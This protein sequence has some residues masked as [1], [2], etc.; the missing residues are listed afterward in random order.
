MDQP[1]IAVIIPCYNVENTINRV[2]NK[3]PEFVSSIIVVDDCSTD[4]TVKHVLSNPDPRLSLIGHKV[5]RGVGGAMLTGFS[6]GLKIGAHILVKLDGDDQMDSNY[7]TYLVEPLINGQADYTKG[8]RFIHVHELK[9]MPL[10]RRIGNLG[11]SFLVKISSGYWDIFDP[12]NGYL[13][14]T[15]D[16]LMDLEPKKISRDFFFETSMLCELHK[17]GAVVNDIALPA[18]YNN[19]GSS[20]R[21]G[22]EFLMF[23]KNLPQ[24]F[25]DRIITQYFQYNFSAGSFFIIQGL[26]LTLFGLIF[27]II[28]WDQSANTGVPATTGTVLLAVL[29]IILGVQFLSQAI[30]LDITSVPKKSII[31]P[32]IIEDSHSMSSFFMQN[33]EEDVEIL[34]KTMGN[35]L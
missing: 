11:L 17:L 20:I 28:K 29:P 4:D 1:K 18:I 32:K 26:I 16:I 3:I 34:R 5:N 10:I 9:K 24:R 30:A 31:K 2:I 23:M 14:I 8:N 22:R 6:Y 25:F 7:L 19:S 33:S 21:I 13:A 35:L 12:T 15:S 27:G